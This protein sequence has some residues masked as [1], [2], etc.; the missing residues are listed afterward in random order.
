MDNIKINSKLKGIC[1]ENNNYSN[2]ILVHYHTRNLEN[3]FVKALTTNLKGSK[4]INPVILQ[5]NLS[6]EE[7]KSNMIKLQIPFAHSTSAVL[8]KK[9]IVQLVFNT[10][11]KINKDTI[12]N[13]LKN[14]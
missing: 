14:V 7:L 11:T 2:A 8:D 3:V 5:Q 13:M 10:D 9:T 4:K 12:H 1:K 6:T